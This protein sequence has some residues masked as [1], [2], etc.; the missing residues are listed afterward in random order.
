MVRFENLAVQFPLTF[1]PG[2][3]FVDR[4]RRFGCVDGFI[5][6]AASSGEKP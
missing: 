3:H 2:P 4:G 6:G 5:L 1:F